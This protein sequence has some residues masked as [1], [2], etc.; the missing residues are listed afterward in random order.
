MKLKKFSIRGFRSLK[1]VSW[2]PSDLNVLI[3]PN[4]SGKSNLLRALELLQQAGV[5]D[6]DGAI[7]HQGGIGALLWDRRAEEIEWKID[8]NSLESPTSA[9]EALE[10]LRYELCLLSYGF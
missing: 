1:D 7:I 2:K 8:V 9:S 4:G 5:G 3:G 10:D 6:F